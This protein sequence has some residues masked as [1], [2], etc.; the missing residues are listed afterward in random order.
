MSETGVKQPGRKADRGPFSSVS[1][2]TLLVIVGVLL[3]AGAAAVIVSARAINTMKNHLV[4][5]ARDEARLA[6]ENA[7]R[8]IGRSLEANPTESLAQVVARPEVQERLDALSDQNQV[9][10]ACILDDE[11]RFLYK[12]LSEGRLSEQECAIAMLDIADH[13]RTDENSDQTAAEDPDLLMEPVIGI[14]LPL[15]RGQVLLGQLHVGVSREMTMRRIDGLSR[16]I[17]TSLKLMSATAVV[18]L[19]ITVV[20][21][22]FVF[23]RH[24]QLVRRT[25]EAEHFANLGALASGFAHEVR[26]PLHAMNLRLEVLREDLEDEKS[27]LNRK[28][29]METIGALQGLIS[30]VNGAIGDFV[31]LTLPRQLSLSPVCV[32]RL[33]RDTVA[34]MESEFAARGVKVTLDLPEKMMVDGDPQALQQVFRDLLQNA[35]KATQCS[36]ARQVAITGAAWRKGWE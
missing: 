3:V 9:V 31:K 30:H 24:F 23:R 20:A 36:S 8:T 16:G 7:F 14:N 29:A 1:M 25:Q 5:A 28:E 10:V 18:L 34:Q 27:E 11:G 19:I 4:L 2:Q 17:S 26:N 21:L 32:T 35:I 6:A 13:T 15:A 12:H 22:T 33:V